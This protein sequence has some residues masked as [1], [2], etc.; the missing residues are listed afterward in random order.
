M[1]FSTV[2]NDA[3]RSPHPGFPRR[4]MP[5]MSEELTF[6]AMS[7]T[8]VHVGFGGIVTPASLSTSF[9]YMRKDDSA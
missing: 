1:V 8:S 7:A 5:A 6:R 4:Q 2:V 9:L 3:P